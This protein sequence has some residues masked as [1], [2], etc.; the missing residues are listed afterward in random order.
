MQW[1]TRFQGAACGDHSCYVVRLEDTH[2]TKLCTASVKMN[3][4]GA[5]KII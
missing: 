5:L 2:M 4:G 3:D 1:K